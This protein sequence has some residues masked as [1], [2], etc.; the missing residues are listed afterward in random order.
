MTTAAVAVPIEKGHPKGLYLLFS[1]EMCERLQYYGM[2]AFLVLYLVDATRGLGWSSGRALS[3]YGWYTACVYLTPVIGGWLA[4]R[5]LGQRLSVILGGTLMMFGQFL[6]ALK[7]VP[8][9]YL[10]FVFLVVGNGFFK[11]NISTMVGQL[12][13]AG[14]ARR[15]SAFTI[16]YMGINLGGM[17]GPLVC[18][19][20]A[21]RVDW[22]LGFA[23]AGLGMG[24]GVLVFAALKGKL[25]GDVGKL[26][27][28]QRKTAAGGVAKAPLTREE[29]ERVVVIF[30]LSLF[31]AVFWA[32]YE[33]GG[34]LMNLFT[35]SKIDRVL[36]GHE[37]PATTF[38][39][40]NSFFIL[41]FAPLFAMLW[42]WLAARGKQPSTPAKMA[43]GLLLLSVGFLLL[44]GAA[45]QAEVVG[46]AAALWMVGAYLFHT[47]G[48][49][50]LSPV[51]LS[52]VTKLAPK[53]FASALMGVWFLSNMAG[54]KLAGMIGTLGER[55]GEFNIFLGI[56]VGSAAAGLLLFALSG[57]LQRMTHGAE[58]ITEAV[59]APPPPGKPA[60]AS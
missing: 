13:R 6:C 46:K 12:Y 59:P 23:S 45:R 27:Y 21:E 34:G 57:T 16:F 58:L 24:L 8:L 14:D 54:N 41:A 32:G 31:V 33:Q 37:I 20:L 11:A 22:S 17:I 15:D 47:L 48:E 10:A 55:F 18:G 43:G 19:T 26:G 40:I 35:K 9:L 3:F 30:V 25:L 36:F 53:A 49:L 51:G 39:A 28:E 2:R 42:T 60:T 56:A 50:A 52:M 44:V 38:Q 7:S 1:A 4:D 5:Y 29:K